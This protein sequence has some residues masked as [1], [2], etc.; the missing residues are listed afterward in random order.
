MPRWTQRPFVEEVPE[1]LARH[2]MS[3]RALAREIDVNP[4]HLSRVLRRRDYQTPSGD[5]SRR[6]A[7]AFDLPEDYFPEYRESVVIA[8]V[9][10][11]AEL[12][13]RLYRQFRG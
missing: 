1:L 4:S 8:R 13:D 10:S 7:L 12:R 11:D 5:L 3:I 2:E 6:V 9:H